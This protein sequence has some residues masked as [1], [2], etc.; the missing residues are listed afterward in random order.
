MN[1]HT[2]EIIPLEVYKELSQKERDEL[3]LIE[4][5]RSDIER[6]SRAIQKNNAVEKRRAKNKAARRSRRAR[7]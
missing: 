4:G 7:R 1:P 6:I 5:S 2:G 3:V